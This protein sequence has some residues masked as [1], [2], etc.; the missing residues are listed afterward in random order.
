MKFNILLIISL[1]FLI[2]FASAIVYENNFIKYAILED[3]GSTNYTSIPIPGA[4]IV[5]YNCTS[6][7]CATVSGL[8]FSSIPITGINMTIAYPTLLQNPNGYG[9]YVYKE[10]YISDEINSTYNGTGNEVDADDFLAKKRN[11][12]SSIQSSSVSS[13]NGTLSVIA[14]VLSPINNSGLLDYTPT[15]L[16]NYYSVNVSVSFNVSGNQSY[17][18][19]LNLSIPFS[20]IKSAL[21]SNNVSDGE[22]NITITATPN[23]AIC[24]NSLSVSSLISNF[25]STG[26]NNSISNSTNITSTVPESISNLNLTYLTNSTAIFNWTNPSS[27]F[28]GTLIYLNGTNIYNL[29][30]IINST[31]LPG[32]TQNT[33]YNLTIYTFN[34]FGI[35]WTAISNIFTTLT[36]TQ[37]ANLTNSTN[38]GQM[39]LTILSPLNQTY[40]I[41]SIT[42]NISLN[43]PG[44]A[45]FSINNG[46]NTSMTALNSTYL[47]YNYTG[48]TNGSYTFNVFAND[49]FGNQNFSSVIFS[50]LL[51]SNSTSSTNS[52]NSTSDS[53][54]TS[55]SA[56]NSG[57][58]SSSSRSSSAGIYHIDNT[59]QTLSYYPINNESAIILGSGKIPE[60]SFS[61]SWLFMAL[62]ILMVLAI[63]FFILRKK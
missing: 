27:N 22:Y 55:S 45:I 20:G 62:E 46:A 21:F 25:T 37:A 40:N 13:S 19:A 29:T 53:G 1:I 18:S 54:S 50:V 59:P 31:I 16:L 4:N 14:N 5:G 26:A 58:S 12:N 41:S 2:S 30:S 44:S 63:L 42:F 24:L 6:L 38:P 11:C 56:G 47:Y 8:L 34:D 33:T 17:F 43:N 3:D 57:A 10:G 35:N 52:T 60:S 48:L 9:I 39:L 28:N 51:P 32:L 49:S 23:D 7:R 36:N 15:E 61:W